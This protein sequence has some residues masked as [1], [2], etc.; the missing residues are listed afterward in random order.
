MNRRNFFQSMWCAFAIKALGNNKPWSE[1]RRRVNDETRPDYTIQTPENSQG[2]V[3]THE[4]HRLCAFKTTTYRDLLVSCSCGKK[5]YYAGQSID[6]VFICNGIVILNYHTDSINP[7][8]L[9]NQSSLLS[10]RP[11]ESPLL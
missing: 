8:W 9:M 6:H 10:V 4:D 11:T 1:T 7:H 3:R 5:K 2:W